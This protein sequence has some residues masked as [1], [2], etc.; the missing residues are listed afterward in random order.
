M[1]NSRAQLV[2]RWVSMARPLAPWFLHGAMRTA[3]GAEPVVEITPTAPGHPMV[4]LADITAGA[5]DGWLRAFRN[6]VAALHRPIIVSFAP[7]ANGSWYAWSNEGPA[8]FIAAWRHVHRI[9]G[10]PQHWCTW[11]FQMSA[12]NTGDPATS[13]FR[14]FWPGGDVVDWV[15][16]DGYDYWP[17]D[18]FE[19]R[20]A[21]SL[22]EVQSFWG[23]P[24]I[25][26][27]TAVSPATGHMAQ[28][29]TDLFNG[30]ARWGLLGL[31]YLNLQPNGGGFYHPDFRL[32]NHPGALA[33]YQTAVN[34]TW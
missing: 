15:G 25:I 30:V 5:K 18:Y 8:A 9:I 22:R 7:E 3:E 24:I 21:A 13:D 29:V 17:S 12:H 4:T 27:E 33:V 10:G 32:D 19:H 11:M 2:V 14:A 26:A 16:L 31:I 34:G 1:T 23:G 28:S 6:Q 20:F